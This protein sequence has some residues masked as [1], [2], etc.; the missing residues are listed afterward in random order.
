MATYMVKTSEMR[1]KAALITQGLR[2][3]DSFIIVH[4]KSPVGYLTPKIPKKLLKELGLKS[5]GEFPEVK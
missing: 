3:G 1:Q 5:Q 4:Y 2:A